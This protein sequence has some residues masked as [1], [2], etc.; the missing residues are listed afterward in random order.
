VVTLGVITLAFWIITGLARANVRV[1]GVVLSFDGDQGRYLYVG[2]VWTVLLAVEFCQGLRMRAVPLLIASVLTAAAVISNF[3]VLREGGAL[4]R[5]QAQITNA[6]LG[7]LNMTRHIVAPSFASNGFT[8]FAYLTAGNYFAA[9][10][11]LGSLGATP[12]QIASGPPAVTAAADAQLIR[13]HSPTLVPSSLPPAAL[14]GR[15]PG[16]DGAASGSVSRQRACLRWSPPA[17]G[18]TPNGSALLLTLPSRGVVLRAGQR[19]ATVSLRRFSATFSPLGTLAPRATA[20]L[21][22]TADDV[23]PPWH[24]EISSSAPVLACG[25]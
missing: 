6:E 20:R 3:E 23:P 17:V 10:R 19:P 12:A 1:G 11:E 18:T 16:L 22:I 25:L 15:P 13:I 24:L 5:G 14:A 8:L 2:A 7:T 4:L 21:R 9:E